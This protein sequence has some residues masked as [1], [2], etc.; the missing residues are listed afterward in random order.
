[1]RSSSHFP[2]SS[3]PR[4][5]KPVMF[6]PGRARLATKPASTGSDTK[7]M[8]TGIVLVA[9]LAACVVVVPVVMMTSTCRWTS[10]AASALTPPDRP[11]AVRASMTMFWPSW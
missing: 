5:V 11:P 8:T 10:S 6:P 2:L 9:R 7:V 4:L 3:G 1:L